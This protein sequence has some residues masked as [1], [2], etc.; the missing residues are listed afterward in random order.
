MTKADILNTFTTIKVGVKYN[1]N[2]QHIEHIPF[3]ASYEIL[4]PV[5][6]EFKGWQSDIT[7]IKKSAEIPERL[8]EYIS[9]IEKEVNVKFGIISVGPDRNQTILL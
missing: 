5:Y 9:F 2:G 8:T 4:E 3:E 6:K 7:N 1:L